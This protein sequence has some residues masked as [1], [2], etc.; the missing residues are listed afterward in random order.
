MAGTRAI[1]LATAGAVAGMMALPTAPTFGATLREALVRTYTGNPTLTGARAGQRAVDENVPI[2]LS[3]GRPTVAGTGSYSEFV[4]RGIGGAFSPARSA[5]AGLNVSVPLYQ[6]GGVR[7]SIRAADARVD[8]GRAQL[9]S[10]EANIFVQAVGSYMD[11][12]RDLAIVELNRGN[13][14][15]LETNVQ[16]SSDRFEVG[17][18]T[19]T[20]VA[21]SQARL[22]IAQSQLQS[23]MA[24][25]D[26]S[27]ENYL[28]I[29]GAVPDAL[30][31]PPP[32]PLFPANADAAADV[33]IE[34][35]PDLIA[36]RAAA[37]AANFDIRTAQASRL[38]T[39]SGFAQGNYTNFLG[40]RPGSVVV[41]PGGGTGDP[42]QPGTIVESAQQSQKTAT[43]G[44]SAN[45]PLYQ[46][47]LPA[48]RVR[49][50]Q[51]RS[52]Q[53]IEQIALVERSVVADSRATYS[54]YSAALGVI[55]SSERAVSASELALEGVRAENSV[56]T[57]NVLD[58]LNAEQEL[59]NVR[60]QLV[61]ARRDAYVAG[62]A[63]L[64]ALG[65]AEARDLGLDGGP[66]Y[67]PTV[68]YRRVRNSLSD[69]RDDPAPVPVAAS[70]A[71]LPS[72]T[73]VV[74]PQTVY[75]PAVPAASRDIPGNMPRAGAVNPVTP[76]AK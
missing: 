63:L 22:S 71:G 56:G 4:Q 50:A 34:N 39:L 7:S 46:G 19:R 44:L 20:D 48:A 18:L 60:V 11:V 42:T 29:I 30:E 58:V 1:A 25:L 66:L 33:A 32:L 27:R 13:V 57:R 64:A 38:P 10:T 21:Q 70:T 2:A 40:S 28:R 68:N 15:V 76:P 69:W 55:A 24:Q 9:R 51:A 43:I 16:A 49:Q 31:P 73:T 45:L 75:G 62:F 6:G 17:D 67:D 5:N 35:N 12:I 72:P 37:R 52:S 47:G 8:S 14:R 54:L 36:A 59:L 61:T 23:A 65:R 26:S 3:Q 74:L 41:N 53:A